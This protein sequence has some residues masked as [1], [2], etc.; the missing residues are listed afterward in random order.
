[1]F[2]EWPKPTKPLPT[3]DGKSKLVKFVGFSI[4]FRKA[5][6]HNTLEGATA[7]LIGAVFYDCSKLIKLDKL[8]LEKRKTLKN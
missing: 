4:D 3:L 8:W 2:I 7:S 5:G 6:R 1:M